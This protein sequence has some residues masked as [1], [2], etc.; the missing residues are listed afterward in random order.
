MFS[1]LNFGNG[2]YFAGAFFASFVLVMLFGRA[3]IPK[4]AAI[5]R[6][7]QPIRSD[8]ITAH[9]EK[10]GTPT[11]GGLLFIP[12][13]II[14]SLLFMELDSLVAWIPLL[15]LAS[16]GFV[17]FID[18]LGKIRHGN[19][20]SGLSKFGRLAAEGVIAVILSFLIDYTM[21][22]NVPELSILL[23]FG[24][25]I[26]AGIFYFAWSYLVIAGTA[27]AANMSDGLDGMLAKI[28][29]CVL[30]VMGV[31]LFGVTRAGFLPSLIFLPEAGAMFPVIGALFGAVLAFL[32]FN[33]KPASVFMGDVGSLALGGMLGAVSLLMKAEIIM[34]VAGLMMVVILLSSMIQSLYYKFVA[35]RGHAPFL[36][37]PLHHHLE[38]KGWSE[39]KITDRFFI[40]TVIFSGAAAALLRL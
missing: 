21:P 3:F 19:S 35:P 36:M 31:A 17:G 28:Y 39:T 22:A 33:A 12:A 20:Y 10:S 8:G 14:A 1:F 13:I 24:I 7:G 18:D 5:Q 26:S 32:W 23:P 15:A 34:A 16:F 40:L 30:G 2:F 25:A 29:L 4:L 9:L 38:R 37:A 6:R 11:M 27:N